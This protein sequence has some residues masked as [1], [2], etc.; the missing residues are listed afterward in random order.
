MDQQQE[1]GRKQVHE[2]Y[3]K[4]HYN[5]NLGYQIFMV[6]FLGSCM[7]A[8]IL[9]IVIRYDG[10]IYTEPDGTY[11]LDDLQQAIMGDLTIYLCIK[12]VLFSLRT[13]AISLSLAAMVLFSVVRY[14]ASKVSLQHSHPPP[15]RVQQLPGLI[16]ILF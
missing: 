11:T 6:L 14:K 10:V 1:Q 16:C 8:N 2:W 12:L 4:M 15:T 9:I 7:V 13:I 3:K 5:A